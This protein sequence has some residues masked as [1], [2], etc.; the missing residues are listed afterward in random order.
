MIL[1]PRNSNKKGHDKKQIHIS[2]VYH[3]DMFT[4]VT[5][6]VSLNRV[7]KAENQVENK[8]HTDRRHTRNAQTLL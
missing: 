2:D 4:W 6:K 7:L 3:T 8:A 1:L 5:S